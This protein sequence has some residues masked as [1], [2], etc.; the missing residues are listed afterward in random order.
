[1]ARYGYIGT[2]PTR[3]SLALSCNALELLRVVTVHCPQ[4]SMQVFVKVLSEMQCVSIYI[5]ILLMVANT[6]MI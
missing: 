6:I 5:I 2:S 1:M 3:P 4:F